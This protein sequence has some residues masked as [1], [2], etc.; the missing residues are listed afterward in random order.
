ML[1]NQTSFL[2]LRINLENEKQVELFPLPL[3][4]D[5]KGFDCKHYAL[6][7]VLN[8]L[9]DCRFID[10]KP[11]PARKRL[12][13]DYQGHSLRWYLKNYFDSTIG[14]VH[15]VEDL[16]VLA[17]IHEQVA[18]YYCEC[19]T[20]TQYVNTLMKAIDQGR[21]PIVFYDVETEVAN[22]TGLPANKKGELEHSVV[23]VGYHFNK[24]NKLFFKV[25][26][27]GNYYNIDAQELFQSTSQLPQTR[28]TQV[29]YFKI[30]TQKEN[31]GAWLI[32]SYVRQPDFMN[33]V[34]K[35]LPESSPTKN[36]GVC[37]KILILDSKIKPAL[38]FAAMPVKFTRPDIKFDAKIQKKSED[39]KSQTTPVN[40]LQ[41]KQWD[42]II[43]R[44]RRHHSLMQNIQKIGLN[45]DSKSGLFRTPVTQKKWDEVVA[46]TPW[47]TY[48]D[49]IQMN[50]SKRLRLFP[51]PQYEPEPDIIPIFQMRNKKII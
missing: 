15:N 22:R 33:R 30:R 41:D 25:S 31:E 29:N 18:A 38:D 50:P 39:K 4:L 9:Y 10:Q 26:Q 44:N 14:E 16:A 43:A 7:A 1:I 32:E 47:Q 13:Q 42:E 35:R 34:I 40:T 5:Q 23:V 45:R 6:A 51:F 12:D 17:E 37:R 24:D 21:A 3:M 28:S 19:E 11:A 20:E 49:R 2:M 46:T 8:W 27:W 48:A 36:N